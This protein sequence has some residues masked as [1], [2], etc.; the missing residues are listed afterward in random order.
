[1]PSRIVLL[2]ACV[3]YPAPLRSFLM[4]LAITDVFQARWS[5]DIHLEWMR[6]V[7]RNRQDVTLK[8]I[9]RVRSLMDANVRDCLVV[10]YETVMPTLSLPDPDDRHVLAAAIHCRADVILTFNLKD[11]PASAL[12][13][14]G[15]VAQHPD[16]FVSGLLKLSPDKVCEAAHNQRSSLKNPPMDASQYLATLERQGLVQ[17][18]SALREFSSSL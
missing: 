9:E 17:T 10:G 11:F 6:N 13:P 4:Y 12:A 16:D 2:D 8:Q 5:N 14:F 1:M 18:V 15:I 3:L 7:L